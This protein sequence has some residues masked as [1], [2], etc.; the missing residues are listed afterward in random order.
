MVNFHREDWTKRNP[1]NSEESNLVRK[2]NFTMR[3]S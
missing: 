1:V 3:V 2:Q